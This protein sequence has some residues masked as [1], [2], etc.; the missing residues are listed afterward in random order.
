MGMYVSVSGWIEVDHHQ[1]A[2]VEQIIAAADDG[3]Y[4]GGWAFPRKPFNWVLRVFYGG[5]IRE[6][7]EDWLLDQV[8]QIATMTPANEDGDMPVGMF[9]L[10]DERGATTSWHVYDGQVLIHEAPELAWLIRE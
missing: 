3:F 6:G 9:V 7:T 2:Q 4:S 1:R 8:R 10:Y 5:D